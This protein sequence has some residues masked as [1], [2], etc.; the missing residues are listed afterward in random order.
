ML[1]MSIQQTAIYGL[2]MIDGFLQASAPSAPEC[3][4]QLITAW[5]LLLT[6]QM[7]TAM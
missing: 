2:W 4:D 7:L 5:C 1:L 3:V 6:L